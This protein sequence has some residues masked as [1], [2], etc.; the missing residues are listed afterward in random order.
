[1]LLG[2]IDMPTGVS[3]TNPK[4]F[5]LEEKISWEN[6]FNTEISVES[7]FCKFIDY[8]PIKSISKH[9]FYADE[10]ELHVVF[11]GEL[12]NTPE[13]SKQLDCQIDPENTANFIYLSF[14][15][16]GINFAE[17]LNG[18]FAIV[19]Y[20]QKSNEVLFF[21]D[22]LG[23]LPLAVAFADNLVYF[24]TDHIGLAKS[25]FGNQKI[26]QDFLV[27]M[28]VWGG[29]HN[30]YATPH[31]QIIHVKP[32]HYL[33]ISENK[34]EHKKYWFPETITTDFNLTQDEIVLN[35]TN[36]LEDAVKIRCNPKLTAGAHLSGGI[37]SGVVAA[38]AR[39]YYTNQSKFYG[40]SWTPKEEIINEDLEFN[41]QLL[42][43]KTALKNNIEPVF[44]SLDQNDYLNS[45]CD[46]RHPSEMF[47]EH[48]TIETA[49]EKGIDVIFSGWGGDDF[50]SMGH[51]GIDADLIRQFHWKYFLKKY[52]LFKPKKFI[53][54][55]VF[56]GLFPSFKREYSKFKV[57]PAIYPF[58]KNVI[59]KNSIKKNKRFKYHSR[60]L[61]HLQLLDLGH[62]SARTADWYIHGQ[63][64]GISY[65]YPLL[66]KRIVEYMLGVPSFCLVGGNNYR[67]LL[68]IIGQE[69]L[70]SEVL[71]NCSKDDPLKSRQYYRLIRIVYRKLIDEL[72]DFKLNPYLYFVD[73]NLLENQISSIENNVNSE[74][75]DERCELLIYLKRAHEFC[76][77]Y[78]DNFLNSKTC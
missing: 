50:I 37:D 75:E 49:K 66:D 23:V 40:F 46:W 39:K 73:F 74:I 16:W 1:M 62:L 36:I 32:G 47:Y 17:K 70:P 51:R 3:M 4:H 27:N 63:R 30:Y 57:E 48:K 53:S 72:E 29:N 12:Y 76:K 13:I 26:N 2:Y 8:S 19:I 78:H 43:E 44:S 61:V 11:Q 5:V 9:Y 52:P 77:G 18:D 15:Q 41:E 69:L 20:K 14:L 45:L 25:V 38:L 31:N 35:L 56:H 33:K 59:G 10:L 22:H 67:I 42:I 6:S 21:R 24:S 60:R 71:N 7:F 65:R 28:F 55:L 34:V 58:I 64:N 68:R 54:G